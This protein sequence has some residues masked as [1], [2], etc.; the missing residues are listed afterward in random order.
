MPKFILILLFVSQSFWAQTPKALFEAANLDYRN[1]KFEKAISQYESIEKS[2][3]QSEEL[4]YNLGNAYYKLNRIAPSIYY[5]EKALLL[6]PNNQDV[7]NNLTFAQ[8]MTIDVIEPMPK[9][10]FQRF[11]EAIIYPISYNTWAWITVFLA[12]LTAS[13]IIAYYFSDES[14]KKRLFFILTFTGIGLFLISLSLGIKA[15]HHYITDQPA[16][17][18]ASQVSIKSEPLNSSSEVFILHEGTKAQI[19]DQEGDWFHIK[20]ANG[21]MGWLKKDKIRLL[22]E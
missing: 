10:I 7:Q 3:F 15:R 17:V 6:D 8:R 19:L 2:G 18:F 12:F 16:I 22:K 20:L 1:G 4:F 21:K 13:S 11:N 5:F 9:T 14:F